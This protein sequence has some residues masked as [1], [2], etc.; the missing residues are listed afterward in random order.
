MTTALITGANRGLGRHFA[1]ELLARGATVYA[2]AREPASIDLP[3][4]RPVA[5]D[6][7]DPDAVAAAAALAGDV[8]LLVNNAGISTGAPLLGDLDAVRAEM[9]VNF[10]GTLSMVRAFAPVLAANGGGAIVNVASALSWF[11]FPGSGAYAVSKAA[12]WNMSNALRLELA[13]QGTQVTSVHLG[14]ADTDMARGIDGPKA[15]PVDVVRRTLDAVAA[16]DLEVVVD[17]WSAMV[18]AS[19]AE[20]PRGFYA[21]FLG[22]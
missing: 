6:I 3:G 8:D 17:E 1:A 19:L 11:A 10:W 16:G 21:R 4:A 2:A 7:T 5:L 22:A 12:N 15:D 20:D 14:L 9:D 18:K 13:G